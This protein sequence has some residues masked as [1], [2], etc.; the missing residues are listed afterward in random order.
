MK[1]DL[2][3]A[4]QKAKNSDA[5][6]SSGRTTSKI[7]KVCC[8]LRAC[9]SRPISPFHAFVTRVHE[10]GLMPSAVLMRMLVLVLVL[11]AAYVFTFV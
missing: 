7:V 9:Q 2:K 4:R 6:A 8:A 10:W 1:H 5:K 11:T 3:T